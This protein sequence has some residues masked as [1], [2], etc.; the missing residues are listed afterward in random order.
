MG[1]YSKHLFPRA[2][3]MALGGPVH[4]EL[5]S[6]VLA[7]ARGRVLEIGFGTGLNL[8]C[9]PP[10][11]IHLT[12]MDTSVHLPSR[13]GRRISDAPFPVDFMQ[14]N[15]ANPLPFSDAS[16]DT[17][18]STWTLCSIETPGSALREAARVLKS[19]GY[20]LFLEHG[21]SRD[22]RTARLQDWFTPVQRRIACGCHLNRRIDQEITQRG[23]QM[24][25][26][27]RFDF[28]GIPRFLGSCYA[29]AAKP[30]P[31]IAN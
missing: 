23:L 9:Y 12:A 7:R 16:F 14:G 21:R 30:V 24:A 25:S 8:S 4:S 11:V 31:V 1:I 28:P 29:G 3:E 6:R 20:F 5:R 13:M 26:L 17:V 27:E 18:T 15:A 10:A 22:P 2:M 19:D